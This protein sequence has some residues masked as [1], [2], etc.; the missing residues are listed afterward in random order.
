MCLSLGPSV[1]EQ[2]E[3]IIPAHAGVADDLGQ[4]AI[5]SDSHRV[6]VLVTNLMLECQC[7]LSCGTKTWEHSTLF[8]L[9]FWLRVGVVTGLGGVKFKACRAKSG[10]GF[11][12]SRPSPH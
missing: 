10:V 5:C 12:G 11:L 2:S 3:A 1:I 4:S 7:S 6:L 8:F 9:E